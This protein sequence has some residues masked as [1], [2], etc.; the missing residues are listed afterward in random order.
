MPQIVKGGKW[1]FG[2]VV[3]DLTGRITVP[4]A[5]W[6]EYGFMVGEKAV[7]IS[8]S[9]RSGGFGLSS[10]K[11]LVGFPGR[12]IAESEFDAAGRVLAPAAL[13]LRPGD[14][15]LAVRGSDRAL[16]FP[17]WGPI[18]EEALKHDLEVYR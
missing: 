9:R 13:E 14:R 7:F 5:A 15:L 12:P 3:V 10:L 4:P 11:L 8:G 1:V 2:W 6:S 17:V 18:I 16:G